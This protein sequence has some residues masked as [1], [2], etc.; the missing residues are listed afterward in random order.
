MLA[1]GADQLKLFTWVNRRKVAGSRDRRV[2]VTV[3]RFK[4]RPTIIVVAIRDAFYLRT[5]LCGFLGCNRQRKVLG[6]GSTD[7]EGH[8]YRQGCVRPPLFCF[9]ITI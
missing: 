3:T 6:P 7:L 1:P 8:D 2:V 9:L 4:N 5:D